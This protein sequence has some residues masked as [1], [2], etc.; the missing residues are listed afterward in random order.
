MHTEMALHDLAIYASVV[1]P[2]KNRLVFY[3]SHSSLL[4]LF[5]SKRKKKQKEGTFCKA[6]SVELSKALKIHLKEDCSLNKLIM[7]SPV[8][9]PSQTRR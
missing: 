4:L 1:L 8:F 2:Y 7:Q 5:T 6:F 3:A 9:S